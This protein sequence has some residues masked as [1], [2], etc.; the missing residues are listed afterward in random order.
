[1]KVYRCDPCKCDFDNF[2]FPWDAICP[3]RAVAEDW[4]VRLV[5]EQIVKSFL[6]SCLIKK[7]SHMIICQTPFGIVSQASTYVNLW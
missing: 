3:S 1:M 5:D 2:G 6:S 7:G 4:T